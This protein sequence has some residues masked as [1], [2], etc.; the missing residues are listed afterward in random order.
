[1]PFATRLRCPRC[2]V[3]QP[4]E[5]PSFE[6]CLGCAAD[7]HAVNLVCDVP[8]DHE[9]AR[10]AL[11]EPAHKSMWDFA[12]LLPVDVGEKVDLGEG[13]TPLLQLSA[14][15]RDIGVPGLWG[16]NES[17]NPTWSHKDRLCAVSVTAARQLGATT[18]GAVSTGNH[19]ASVAAYAARAGLRSVI[20][21]LQGVPQAMKSLIGAYGSLVVAA[22]SVEVRNALMNEAVAE[23]GVYPVSNFLK[24]PIG[25]TPFGVDGYKTVAYEIW[26]QLEGEVPDWVCVPV[27]YGDCISGV[28]RGFQDLVELGLAPRVPRLIAAEVFGA[29]GAAMA[30]TAMP[31]SGEPDST[32]AFSIATT[33]ATYQSLRALRDTDG[34]ACTVDEAEIRAAQRM[35]GGGEGIFAE[36]SSA[37][38]VAAIA[39][40]A[41]EGTIGPA[42]TAVALLTS[43]GLKDPLGASTW[44]E[45]VVDVSGVADLAVILAQA[46][47]PHQG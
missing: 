30:G 10:K 5:L 39:R 13:W 40:L 15:G 16:K 12:A 41:A 29:V 9:L 45:P 4:P 36:A 42:D 35:L 2:G 8:I 22:P 14:T 20:F 44:E 23:F 33:M 17:A 46:L 11:L 47:A 28:A 43:T 1:M 34:V 21:T 37:T 7:G 31:R 32:S 18:I 24:P 26:H 19:G 25:S 27:G 6:G 38:A 3:P